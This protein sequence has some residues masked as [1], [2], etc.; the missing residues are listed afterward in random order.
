MAGGRAAGGRAETRQRSR[1]EGEAAQQ[2]AR[3]SWTTG[4]EGEKGGGTG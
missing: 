4:E 1:A 3:E 2:I